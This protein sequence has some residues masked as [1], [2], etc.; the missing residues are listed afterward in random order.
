MREP[1][2]WIW[3]HEWIPIPNRLKPWVLG[4]ALGVKGERL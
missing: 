1:W 3:Y 2:A 4:R